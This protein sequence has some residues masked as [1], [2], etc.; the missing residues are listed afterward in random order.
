MARGFRSNQRLAPAKLPLVPAPD[1]NGMVVDFTSRFWRDDIPHGLCVV[2]GL[3]EI[4]GVELPRVREMITVHQGFM[5][6]SYLQAGSTL[7]GAHLA[8]TNAPQAHGV[9]D[10]SGLRALLNDRPAHAGRSS[11]AP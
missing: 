3:A 8:E 2:Q 4:V 9:W 10:L 1:G 7:G 11:A 5:G 6:K